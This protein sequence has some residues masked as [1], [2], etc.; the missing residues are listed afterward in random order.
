VKQRNDVADAYSTGAE[1]WADGPIRIYGTMAEL[2]IARSPIPLR[3]SRLLD[4]GT[5]TGAASRPALAAGAQVTAV[6]RAF[7]MLQ[8]DRAARPP[9][10]VADAGALPVRCDAFDVVVAAF[11]LNHLDEPAAGVRQAAAALR[12]GGFLLAS[13]YAR[14]DDHPVKRAAE[15]ALGEFGWEMPAWYP[16]LKAAMAAWGTTSDAAAAIERGGMEPVSVEH[17]DLAFPELGPDALVRWRLGMA[18]SAGFVSGLDDQQLAALARRASELLGPHPEPLVR[19]VI[20]IVAR[21]H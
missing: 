3:G 7:G 19:S 8:T 18:Q 1:A 6:D 12:P 13:T 21:A 17:C 2:L 9:G 20:F 15:Q 14:D 11:A 4:L 16:H 10:V 5:G